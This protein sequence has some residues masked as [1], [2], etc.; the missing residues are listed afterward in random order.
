VPGF[1]GDAWVGLLAPAGTPVAIVERLN[2]EVKQILAQPEVRERLAASGATPY[3]LTSSEFLQL[4]RSE[5]PLWA[6][7]VKRSGATVD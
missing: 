4:I 3:A 2:G 7:V 1:S 6:E 5:L